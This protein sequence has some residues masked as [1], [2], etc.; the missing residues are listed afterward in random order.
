MPGALNPENYK[1]SSGELDQPLQFYTI[2]TTL[3]A[4]GGVVDPASAAVDPVPAFKL[5]GGVSPYQGQQLRDALQKVGEEWA[6]IVVRYSPSA[7]PVEGMR[8]VNGFTGF[9]YEVTGVQ[10]IGNKRRRVEVTCR[11]LS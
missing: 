9:E 4:A 2:A 5:F 10:P 6:V 8:V 11:R 7:L 3:D 1:V